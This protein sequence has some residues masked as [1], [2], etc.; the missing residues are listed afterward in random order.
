MRFLFCAA[1]VE[2]LLPPSPV[3]AAAGAAGGLRSGSSLDVDKLVEY[4]VRSQNYDGGIGL[5]PGMESHGGSTYCTPQPR[6]FY[7]ADGLLER[8]E[9]EMDEPADRLLLRGQARWRRWRC[10]VCPCCAA[11]AD[12]GRCD[13][14]WW[15]GARRGT[16]RAGCRAA[17]TSP[18][19][20][21]TPGGS[22]PRSRC[23]RPSRAAAGWRERSIAGWR[24]PRRRSSSSAARSPPQVRKNKTARSDQPRGPSLGRARAL[25]RGRC[26]RGRRVRQ[27]RGGG[28]GRG[29]A[30][31]LLL[32][33][34]ALAARLPRAA[35]GLPRARHAR[36]PRVR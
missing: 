12:G 4:I 19:T 29:P 14:R 26:C 31:H 6:P 16:A 2:R 7:S 15:R 21:A 34:G 32:A 5:G 1:A 20:A 11:A 30:A 8:D 13:R 18:A 25:S 22:A 36:R 3:G 10:S 24:A 9:L 28:G 17:S 27:V 23:S 35:G 33:G